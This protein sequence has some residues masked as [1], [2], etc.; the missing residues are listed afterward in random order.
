MEN[1]VEIGRQLK[2]NYLN[3]LDTGIPLPNDA[4]RKER[5]SLYEEDGVI[6]QSPIIEFVRKYDGTETLTELCKRNNLDPSIAEILNIGLLR[7]DDGSERKLY[8]HQIKAVEDVL[9]HNKNIVA[10]TGTGSGKTEC[11]MIPLI[12]NITLEA[13]NWEIPKLR[14]RAMRALILYPLN[15]LA[16][17]QM[18]RLRKSLDSKD[19]KLWLDRNCKGNRITF[20]RYTGLTE[21]KIKSL[22][23]R[24]LLQYQDDWNEFQ[25]QLKENPFS[26]KL[27]QRGYSIPCTDTDSAE[28]ILRCDMQENPPDI[29]IT[30]YSMLNIM[31]MR[32]AE[33]SMFEKTKAWLEEDKNHVFTLVV[34]ELHTY[35]GT[36]G[37]EVSYI[38]KVLL[39][40]LGLK[41]NSSQIRFLASSASLPDTTGEF[42][43]DFFNCPIDDKFTIITDKKEKIDHNTEKLPIKVLTAISK[44]KPLSKE[45]DLQI[46]TLLKNYGY[47]SIRDF[48]K[49]T[50]L[51]EKLKEILFDNQ[52]NAPAKTVHYIAEH[53][54]PD[55]ENEDSLI[56]ASLLLINLAKDENGSIIQ[57][58]R[59]HYF[60]R[61]IDN[62][63]ICSSSQC[64]QLGRFTSVDRKFGKLYT[65]PQNRCSCGGKILEAI[66]CRQCGEI[67]LSGYEEGNILNS[68]KPLMDLNKKRTIIYKKEDG[69]EIFDKKNWDVCKYESDSGKVIKGINGGYLYYKWPD[70]NIEFPII[71]PHCGF[72]IRMTDDNSF[73]ALYRHGTGVQ[74]VNQLFADSLMSVLRQDSQKPKLV[75]FS[76]SR[77]AAA[78]LSAGIEL[79]HYRDTLRN[80]VLLS[81]TFHS[82]VK[83]YLQ[84]LRVGEL[85]YKDFPQDVKDEIFS[86]NY[87]KSIFS[88]VSMELQGAVNPTDISKLDS[89]FESKNVTLEQIT[90]AVIKQ[91]LQTGIN[92][93]GPYPSFQNFTE[94]NMN[95]SWTK[96]VDWENYKFETNTESKETFSNKIRSRCTIEIL[97]TVFGSNKRT[98][99]NLALGYFKVS[100]LPKRLNQ[101]FADSAI[102][103]LGE[104]WKIYD[105]NKQPTDSLAM[106]LYKFNSKINGEKRSKLPDKAP[107]LWSTISS[108]IDI[109]VLKASDDFR[110][111]G[112]NLEF[113]KA[114]LGDDIIRCT[115]C[116]TINLHSNQK[117]CTFCQKTI[118]DK[119]HVKL[120]KE[121]QSSYY[122]QSD[123]RKEL[124]RLHCEELT[125]QTNKKQAQTR[126]RCF[127]GLMS[128][129]ENALTD[130]IDLLSVTTTMEAGVDIGSLSAVMMGNVPPQ[131]F[132]YQQRVGRAGRRGS[133]LS[134]ALTI[135]KVNSHDQLHY[136]QPERM[137]AGI[138]SAPYI[139]LRS[140]EILKRFIIKEVLRLAFMS[141]DLQKNNASVH[142]E[143]GTVVDWED[144]KPKITKWI[145]EN[146]EKIKSIILY[147]R[148]PKKI[149]DKICKEIFDF[150]TNKLIISIDEKLKQKE[151]IQPDL[152]ERLAATGLL[153]MFGF[154]TQVRYLY[155]RPVYKF[156]PEDVTDRPID[157]ALQTFTPG[158]Q[159]VKDKKVLTSI[160]FIG[161]EPQRGSMQPKEN[162]G[163]ATFVGKK[164]LCCKTCGY[165]AFVDKNNNMASCP[166]CKTA[167]VSFED[168]ATP[169][170]FRTD[171]SRFTK[172]FNGRFDW[173]PETSETSID[174]EKT[175][176]DLIQV[177]KTNFL[178]GN[179]RDPDEGIVNTLNTNSGNLF[180][181][182]KLKNNCGWCSP[183]KSPRDFEFN[184]NETRQIALI[185][186][187]ITGVLEVSIQT[188][189]EN[190][191]IIPD[192][193]GSNDIQRNEIKGAYLSWGTLIRKCVASYLDIETTELSTNYFIRGEQNGIR[194]AVYLIEKL[195]NGAGYTNH[196]GTVPDDEKRKIF[197]TPLLK[198]GYMYSQ[199]IDRKH[200]S[201]CD[202]SC[203]DCLRDY[204]NQQSHSILNWRIGLDLAAI[205]ADSS[206]IPSYRN[207]YWKTLIE[208][209]VKLFKPEYRG[210]LITVEINKSRRVLTHP[211]WSKKYTA[212]LIKN[213]CLEENIQ[214]VFITRFLQNLK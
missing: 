132:N 171:F 13:K 76:D 173:N 19:V 160:G 163:L 110:I 154:P 95:L 185:S 183:E 210:E 90:D 7:N 94:G 127:I 126:Q 139:D 117:V 33:N 186:T 129:R 6:M 68:T 23:N 195:E 213:S 179:N 137:V 5:R 55:N 67:F 202:S 21:G 74:K 122:I 206:Y 170:G 57:P 111:T 53:L 191:C 136:N 116:G 81:L 85:K 158:A 182:Q 141:I 70:D 130:E 207:L 153:P 205:S 175:K 82:D 107:V 46:S 178:I 199:L 104:N 29:L 91:L 64:N 59:A 14:S 124:S 16:E 30:N 45:S 148:D 167:L 174:S 86:D 184:P 56:E 73:T 12:A 143:F 112:Q 200:A 9:V 168:V 131:R 34:D 208:N 165:T 58:M 18:V 42:V 144:Y 83:S 79:D 11:F 63:W 156:P 31:T 47:N 114:N 193:D 22:R 88:L 113:V 119:D 121:I 48:I 118:E 194:P 4:Y 196:L 135:A 75:L 214:Q 187:K 66:V 149:N 203:Y 209:R 98:F 142:G 155:E 1:P 161:Y 39:D 120:T 38:V 71:C 157:M 197:I 147:L 123:S 27:T 164:V 43:S 17:D 140:L 35:R 36:A 176:V 96:C 105:K 172:D 204:Y 190:I 188:Q 40:R 49:K 106:R 189:N 80:A 159:I 20:G 166:I 101:V 54:F 109:H 152:S 138:P 128:Q 151:F 108:L 50:F 15:A 69:E 99:E 198:D 28:M 162:D 211:L 201:N 72:S 51:I 92:P 125:G 62:I 78:K 41:S 93:A 102:R 44:I 3:Y 26:P 37:T 103:I 134:L 177:Q 150:V 25:R 65:T 97:N 192:F 84:K 115:K 133:A 2:N 77:Q 87:L 24:D 52:D 89:Y 32:K 180:T 181:I 61:N 10:T 60:A 145:D 100:K 169:N 212:S 146:H 8:E